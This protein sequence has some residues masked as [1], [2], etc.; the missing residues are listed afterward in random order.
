LEG[1]RLGAEDDPDGFLHFMEK[2]SNVDDKELVKTELVRQYRIAVYQLFRASKCVYDM[3]VPANMDWYE[4]QKQIVYRCLDGY[5]EAFHY[6]LNWPV[7][8]PD[9]WEVVNEDDENREI[10]RSLGEQFGLPADREHEQM[11]SEKALNADPTKPF[12]AQSRF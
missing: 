7:E 9:V 2:H 5:N 12:H 6:L 3:V 8:D 1:L 4:E 10:A 11:M